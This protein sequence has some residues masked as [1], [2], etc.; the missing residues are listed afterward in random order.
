MDGTCDD[1][2][3]YWTKWVNADSPVGSDGDW[4]TLGKFAR[5]NVCANPSGIQAK[6]SG[7]GATDVLHIHK[8]S[9]FWCINAENPS[10]CADFSVRFC[11]P[12]YK[13]GECSDEGHS[14]T[15]WYND[16]WNKK[17]E[18]VWVS[19]EAELE[20]L[21]VNFDKLQLLRFYIVTTHLICFSLTVKL[22]P[23]L[24]QLSLK[25]ELDQPVPHLSKRMYGNTRLTWSNIYPQLAI[26]VITRSKEN[27]THKA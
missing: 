19:N 11:C 6:T 16:E 13:T 23:A 2:D 24:I 4:E 1:E 27:L 25:F 22:V 10:E 3:Y 26:D 21:Q 14:W 12:K 18:R 15:G 9:G 5:M 17:N 7:P 20:L 8:E